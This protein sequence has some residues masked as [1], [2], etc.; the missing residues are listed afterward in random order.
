M[1]GLVRKSF[2]S[3]EEVRP[4]EEGMGKLE[5][6]GSESGSAIRATLQP[7]WQWSKHVKPMMGTESCEVPHLGY[8]VT[9]RLKVH[10]DDGEEQE[11]T[12]GDLLSI[13]PGHDAWVV[14]DRPCVFIDWQGYAERS[15]G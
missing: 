13:A 9:G 14:G 12:Q 6:V 3:P 15:S 11:F 4:A 10:M 5:V 8:L 7:G 2:D 1:A